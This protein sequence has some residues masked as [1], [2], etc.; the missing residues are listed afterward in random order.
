M[1]RLAGPFLLV[2]SAAPLVMAF[3]VDR[4]SDAMALAVAALFAAGAFVCFLIIKRPSA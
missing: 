3:V 2:Q 4:T 1:G